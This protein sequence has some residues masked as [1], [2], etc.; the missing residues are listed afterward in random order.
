MS[1]LM[2]HQALARQQL[3]LK[4]QGIILKVVDGFWNGKIRE[5]Q[6]TLL[7][8]P[9][10]PTRYDLRTSDQEFF[11]RLL[12]IFYLQPL[13]Q[14]RLHYLLL[15]LSATYKQASK[16]TTSFKATLPAARVILER[17]V[18]AREVLSAVSVVLVLQFFRGRIFTLFHVRTT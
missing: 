10:V 7:L 14:A 6:F 11:L 17:L 5:P 4:P 8:Q 2:T 16:S 15:L 18:I 9:Q 1:I 12:E 3:R 13:R